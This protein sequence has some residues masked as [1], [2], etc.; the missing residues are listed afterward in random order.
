MSDTQSVSLAQGRW[1]S[2]SVAVSVSHRHSQLTDDLA[3]WLLATESV[4]HCHC[5][6]TDDLAVS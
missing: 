2:S 6:L 1:A 3:G 5:H 4:A